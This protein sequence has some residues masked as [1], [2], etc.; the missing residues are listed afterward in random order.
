MHRAL[1]IPLDEEGFKQQR[2]LQHFYGF[3]L[4]QRIDDWQ[5]HRR[6]AFDLQTNYQHWH[7]Y[8]ATLLQLEAQARSRFL[9]AEKALN[10]KTRS[11]RQLAA[12]FRDCQTDYTTLQQRLAEMETMAPPQSTL[13]LK[14]QQSIKDR[15]QR[16]DLEQKAMQAD[17]YAQSC[18]EHIAQLEPLLND[19]EGLMNNPKF[20]NNPP[21]NTM[22]ET[23]IRNAEDIDPLDMRV[24]AAWEKLARRRE[25]EKKSPRG[26]RF[27]I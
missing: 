26:G 19:I 4:Q 11:L 6:I 16:A 8:A 18:N 15:L 14:E 5:E 10:D 7:G 12:N 20:G 1:D 2:N 27:K 23:K 25:Q 13:A 17:T 3:T 21:N 22:L 9:Q 24:Q